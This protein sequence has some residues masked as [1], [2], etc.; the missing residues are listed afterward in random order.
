MNYICTNSD[1]WYV[2]AQTP[3]SCLCSRS[4][5]WL[6]PPG[7]LLKILIRGP[8]PGPFSLESLWEGAGPRHQCVLRFSRCCQL[9]RSVN[10]CL[11]QDFILGKVLRAEKLEDT[12]SPEQ[13]RTQGM[14]QALLVMRGLKAVTNFHPGFFLCHLHCRLTTTTSA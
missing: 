9:Y 3:I 5:P 10:H 7:E 13:R 8:H 2:L 12:Q 6:E 1:S 11:Y 14:L 4:Q